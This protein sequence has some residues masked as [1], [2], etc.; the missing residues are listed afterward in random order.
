MYGQ[1]LR[2][3]CEKT[4]LYCYTIINGWAQIRM[5]HQSSDVWLLRYPLIGAD[6]GVF[7][8]ADAP[9]YGHVCTLPSIL[10]FSVHFKGVATKVVFQ[11]FFL[12]LG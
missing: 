12:V 6:M 11:I 9:M 3:L 8:V 4:V 7:Q 10:S 5:V 2:F 1:Y